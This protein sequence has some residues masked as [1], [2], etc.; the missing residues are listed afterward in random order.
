MH[1]KEEA[2][3]VEFFNQAP[4]TVTGIGY[5]FCM[6]CF[7]YLTCHFCSSRKNHWE[8]GGHLYHQLLSAPTISAVKKFKG[9]LP[10][11]VNHGPPAENSSCGTP[12]RTS[13]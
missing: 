4:V 11:H 13:D 10:L 6:I 12:I 2:Q 9:F 1:F 8:L 5:R 3:T 7:V